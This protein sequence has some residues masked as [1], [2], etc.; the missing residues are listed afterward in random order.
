MIMPVGRSLYGAQLQL[1][2]RLTADFTIIATI[3]GGLEQ[4][5][6]FTLA[7]LPA[8]LDVLANVTLTLPDGSI[9][10]HPRRFLRFPPPPAGSATTTFQVDH[11]RGGSMLTNGV[12]YIATGWFAGGYTGEYS[13]WPLTVDLSPLVRSS[14][15]N[16]GANPCASHIQSWGDHPIT[17]GTR[18]DAGCASDATN[19]DQTLSQISV[20]SEW[21]RLGLNFVRSGLNNVNKTEGELYLEALA[22][23][24]EYAL[25]QT[26]IDDVALGTSFYDPI[27]KT[28]QPGNECPPLSPLHPENKPCS[29]PGGDPTQRCCFGHNSSMLWN[30]L[31]NNFTWLAGQQAY[32]GSYG[33]DDCCHV[34][35]AEKAWVEYG[36]IAKVKDM[37]LTLDPYHFI[38]GTIACDNL[39]MWSET[40]TGL[41]LDIVMKEN[42]GGSIAPQYW[43]AYDPCGSAKGC[44]KDGS[45]GASIQQGPLAP[46]PAGH[47][48]SGIGTAHHRQFP[49]TYEP[50]WNMPDPSS[51]NSPRE[52]MAFAWRDVI[53]S[54][55]TSTNW[56]VY[57]VAEAR[58][59]TLVNQMIPYFQ[60][61]IQELLPS[62]HSRVR[63]QQ[64]AL[65][66]AVVVQ[67]SR[68]PSPDQQPINGP[69]AAVLR[70]LTEETAKGEDPATW[71]CMHLVVLS[72]QMQ[73]Q[74]ITYK[75]TDLPVAIRGTH[76]TASAIFD[77]NYPVAFNVSSAG[78]A[79]FSDILG[80]F[81]TKVY[82]IGCPKPPADA[83]N[84]VKDPSF[85]GTSPSA[86]AA[87]SPSGDI[88]HTWNVGCY[89]PANI[90]GYYPLCDPRLHLRTSTAEPFHGR[91]AARVQIPSRATVA[92]IP[93]PQTG[94]PA[95]S[96]LVGHSDSSGA[97]EYDVSVWARSSPAEVNATIRVGFP[98]QKSVNGTA[99]ATVWT[100]SSVT[101]EA[102][103][104]RQLG[105]VFA[106]KSAGTSP[107]LAQLLLEPT[108]GTAA[109]VWLDSARISRVKGK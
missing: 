64:K 23:V 94:Y 59:G 39:W 68:P 104:W 10:S 27:T 107:L 75:L 41:G 19:L 103:A 77:E 101:L 85:E 76:V 26:P 84:F 34:M 30:N 16:A 29:G 6:P 36:N 32:A 73:P 22:S 4:L 60:A 95:E 43:D 15:S 13:G 44:R 37:M 20:A 100:A 21:G 81:D 63:F 106:N 8:T 86:A 14:M 5:V 83:T 96:Q 33:C 72:T 79:S 89:Q 35:F 2:A 28:V 11:E 46:G 57:N 90:S 102:G 108:V 48:K 3:P 65:P 49:M 25:W 80:S 61:K 1:R 45:N 92:L 69:A 105:I 66:T 98:G 55:E 18:R 40:G 50:I 47:S 54:G 24:G 109:T 93:F 52:A 51:F 78:S 17:P 71:Y 42:Y 9:V 87:W 99:Q 74:M 53:I 91:H 70:L 88:A 38:F 62:F 56:F 31:K 67:S 58:D 97:V 12:P 7:K 82:R